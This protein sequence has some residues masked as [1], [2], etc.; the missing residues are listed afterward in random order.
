MQFSNMTKPNTASRSRKLFRD[1]RLNAGLYVLLLIPVVYVFIFNYIPMYGVTLAFKKYTIKGGI[2]NSPWIGM[3]QFDRFFSNAKCWQII[4]NTIL[5]SL[6]SLIAGFPIP[7]LLAIGLN[8]IRSN[9]FRKTVQMIS[10]APHFLSTVIIVSIMS[11]LFNL[12]FGLVNR[13]V[14]VLGGKPKDFMGAP[15]AFR[16]LYVWSGVWQNAGYDAI[17]YISAL[18]TVDLQLHEAASVDGANMWQRVWHI[19]FPGILPTIVIMLILRMGS[20]LSVGFEKVFLMQTPTNIS[21]SEIIST[22]VYSVGLTNKRPD[23]S[24]STAV[25]LFQNGVSFILV[26]LTNALSKRVSGSGII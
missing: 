5:L 9:K 19:D 21:V 12:Q 14:E 4:W 15:D 20:L 13:L 26:M 6:Y 18:S 7:I 1:I 16:H 23:F 10:Y 22:Y 8:H 24:Y 11:Q 2:F 25:G 3:Y 17:I